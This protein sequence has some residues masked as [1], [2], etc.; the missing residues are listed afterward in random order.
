[1]LYFLDGQNVGT[2]KVIG[3][4]VE[5]AFNMADLNKQIG[6]KLLGVSNLDEGLLIS[7][8]VSLI[9]IFGEFLCLKIKFYLK[10]KA[11]CL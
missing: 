7:P 9:N 2:S 6:I 4:A 11:S 5:S 10:K 8:V 3:E 1:M